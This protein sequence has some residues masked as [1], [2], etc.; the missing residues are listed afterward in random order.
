M[1]AQSKSSPRA[2]AAAGAGAGRPPILVA[3]GCLEGA[4]RRIRLSRTGGCRRARAPALDTTGYHRPVLRLLLLSILLATLLLPLAAA[5]IPN[6]R[7]A[8]AS[9][10]VYVLAAEVGYAFLLYFIYPRLL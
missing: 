9:L 10:L 1:K 5:R 4:T 8:F 6:P 2:A 7:R 3:A